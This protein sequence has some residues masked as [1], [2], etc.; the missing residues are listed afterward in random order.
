MIGLAIWSL[1]A[2]DFGLWDDRF[3]CFI[4]V[5]EW[6]FDQDLD[7]YDY[8]G[9]GSKRDCDDQDWHVYP[10][11]PEI[12]D[13]G[14][15]NN[16]DGEID[17]DDTDDVLAETCYCDADGDGAGFSGFSDFDCLPC[18]ERP[19]TD[20]C[21]AWSFLPTDCDDS[22]PDVQ[23]KTWY[24][25]DDGDGFGRTDEFVE[26]CNA[27]PGFSE[28]D[29]D[30]ND[31][32]GDL[33]PAFSPTAPEICN[34]GLDN[35]CSGVGVDTWCGLELIEGET[36]PAGGTHLIGVSESDRY[37]HS[38]GVL[39]WPNHAHN[40]TG[41]APTPVLA[42]GIRLFD[43]ADG[44]ANNVG[45]VALYSESS[46]PTPTA[47]LSGH[48]AN[49]FAGATLAAA[50]LVNDDPYPDM[51]VGAFGGATTD[52]GGAGRAYVIFG[53]DHSDG[54]LSDSNA[55][56][57]EGPEGT[58]ELGDVV[59]GGGDV[60]GD[61]FSDVLIGAPIADHETQ[62]TS[63]Q[64]AAYLLLGGPSW[65]NGGGDPIDTA[66]TCECT[67]DSDTETCDCPDQGCA[68]EQDRDGAAGE[69]LAF[70]GADLNEHAGQAVAFIGDVTGDGLED[71]AIGANLYGGDQFGAVH[72]VFGWDST[73]DT[74]GQVT[75]PTDSLLDE[76]E[77]TLYGT[78][79]KAGAGAVLA[80][81]GDMDGDGTADFAVGAPSASNQFG[82]FQAG[83]VYLVMGD[84]LQDLMANQQP[85]ADGWS[86]EL[87]PRVEGVVPEEM[88]GWS[89]A[90]IG[91]GVDTYADLLIGSAN[92]NDGLTTPKGNNG[93][94]HLIRGH[95]EIGN[96]SVVEPDTV[97]VVRP[98]ATVYGAA[99]TSQLGWTVGGLLPWNDDP[100]VLLGAA[101]ETNNATSDGSMYLLPHAWLLACN[102]PT[103]QC[104]VTAP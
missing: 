22:N 8:N 54:L 12:C 62:C 46:L 47:V 41:D 69:F 104:V 99:D 11:A 19:A 71:F 4:V 30:C 26:A 79:L 43:L 40:Q 51:V 78:G 76:R 102:D 45:G 42:V 91:N 14:K 72:L 101:P 63:N 7:G 25:D 6:C 48:E 80:G 81:I 23:L 64:G 94:V 15:D 32:A 21:P 2:C 50:G 95:P 65:G 33:G 44:T 82:A 60:N 17:L 49:E 96:L 74:L 56:V 20:D 93:V 88:L 66:P 1:V 97:P 18:E 75:K 86:L 77:R 59:A 52:R 36:L 13:D 38:V 89:I 87:F 100:L 5:N 29:G 3:D 92:A 58:A 84:Q 9:E 53:T 83:V 85:D 16:C 28:L 68:E 90:G 55:V 34:D 31:E 57:I 10:G 27:P 73:G 35:N 70:Y 39:G 98:N 103:D 61:G 37:G 67:Y 24:A